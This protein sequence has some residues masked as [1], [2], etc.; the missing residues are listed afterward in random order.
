M[1]NLKARVLYIKL[2]LNQVYIYKIISEN[3]K[4]P[5]KSLKYTQCVGGA[6]MCM[7]VC[8]KTKI[9]VSSILERPWKYCNGEAVA[10]IMKRLNL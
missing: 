8:T 7:C 5:I 10:E 4:Q 1:K 9:S 3:F 2:I 6:R